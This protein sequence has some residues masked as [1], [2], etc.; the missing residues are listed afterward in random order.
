MEKLRKQLEKEEK[1]IAKV[2]AKAYK[3]KLESNAEVDRRDRSFLDNKNKKRKRSDS[4][5][6]GESKIEDANLSKPKLQ[7][8]T[9]IVADPLTPTSQP[10]LADEEQSSP[11]KA[12]YPDGAVFQANVS[13]GPEDDGPSSHMDPPTQDASVS[14]SDLSSDSSSMNSEDTTSSS[15]SSSDDDSDEEAPD[16]A[17]TKRNRPEKVAPPKRANPKQICRG[18]LHKGLC[19]RGIRCKYLH[20][21]PERGSRGAGSQEVKRGEGRKER[22]GLYQRVSRQVHCKN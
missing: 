10:A 21:L 18:F 6:S 12:L 11:P 2:E 8:A 13:S 3:D 4:S 5:G 19:K 22:V 17:S 16:E 14:M 20:V 9:N 1:R 15:G 7:E